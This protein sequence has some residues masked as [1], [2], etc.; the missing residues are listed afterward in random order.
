VIERIVKGRTSLNALMNGYRDEL[1]VQMLAR[2]LRMVD[3]Q[4]TAALQNDTAFFASTSLIAIGGA[5][6]LLHSSEE[7]ISVISLLPFGA[8]PSRG[9]I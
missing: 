5:L 8:T 1:M 3:A 7:I 4:V 9:G 6:T 2:D